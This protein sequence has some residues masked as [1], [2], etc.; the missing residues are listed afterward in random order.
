[1]RK[2]AASDLEGRLCRALD[3]A[4]LVVADF[5]ISGY[6]D[7]RV[8]QLSFG[9]EKVVAEAAMLVYAASGASD[10]PEVQSRVEAV[11]RQLVPYVRSQRAMADMALRPGRVFKHAVPHALLTALGHRDDAMDQF[12]RS[13]C[14]R[15]MDLAGDFPPSARL[16][17]DWIASH[18]SPGWESR[19]EDRLHGTFLDLPIDSLSESR[20]E[21][22]SLTHLLFYLT[23]FAR[24][25][26]AP[27]SRRPLGTVLN[28]VEGLLLRCLDVED[29]DL[30]GELLMAWPQLREEWSPA[31]TFAFR[32]LARVEDEVGVLPCGNADV[33]RLVELSEFERSRYARATAYHTAFV[34]GFLCAVSLRHGS[35]PPTT[36]E[37]R[38]YPDAVWEGFWGEIDANQGHWLQDFM[39]SSSA[40]KRVLAPLL[41]HFAI[42]QKL[43]LHDFE[44]LNNVL[45]RAAEAGLPEHPLQTRAT[46]LLSS[47]G[48]AVAVFSGSR[49][50]PADS[51]PERIPP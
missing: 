34:M 5:G 7:V 8:P 31:A 50:L 14:A 4:A 22:Y 39:Q 21:A 47:L 17:R 9:P 29:Y 6:K 35:R 49:H 30:S 36:V 38:Q 32:V 27:L 13:Q 12:F 20:E 11:G 37:G 25:P 48:V 44:G 1:M 23:D 10:S 40:E 43:R 42:I 26:L 24:T 41:C 46:D 45:V 18:L 15:A 33:E 16:E 2:W 19:R 28:E 3:L 51:V